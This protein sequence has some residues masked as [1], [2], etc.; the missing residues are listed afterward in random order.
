MDSHDHD[1]KRIQKGAVRSHTKQNL[2][3]KADM[4]S[5]RSEI[6]NF[7]KVFI[8]DTHGYRSPLDRVL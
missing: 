4:E 8:K 3:K 6:L 1:K 2:Y 5:I 7:G